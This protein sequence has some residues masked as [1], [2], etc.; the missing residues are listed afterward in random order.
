MA[1]KKSGRKAAP[2]V[3]AK[4]KGKEKKVDVEPLRK[5]AEE[6]KAALTRAENEA[7]A[8]RAQAKSTEAVAKKAYAKAVGP[9]R[10]ACRKA[11]VECEFPGARGENMTPA[12]RFLV[13]KVKDGVKVAIKG[14]PKTEEVIPTKALSESVSKAAYAYTEKHIGPKEKIGNKGGY[15]AGCSYVGSLSSSAG[16]SRKA[17]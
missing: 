9:Y 14:Q 8:L 2:K 13:E 5:K 12:V 1:K 16:E 10:D 17:A 3:K 11:G 7:T 4:P 15:V 6:A